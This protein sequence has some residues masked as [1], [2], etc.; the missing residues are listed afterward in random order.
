M[1]PALRSRGPSWCAAD[2]SSENAHDPGGD[3]PSVNR[4]RV[5]RAVW[6]NSRCQVREGFTAGARRKSGR[7]GER[8]VNERSVPGLLSKQLEMKADA[9]PSKELSPEELAQ[10]SGGDGGDSVADAVRKAGG[11]TTS[12][13]GIYLRYAFGTV[14]TTSQP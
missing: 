10:V 11:G 9:E 1:S 5:E 7:V 14:S 6:R 13:G 3:P 12:G 8:G 2:A 4:A